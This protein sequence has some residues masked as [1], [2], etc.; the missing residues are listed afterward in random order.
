MSYCIATWR[1]ITVDF[2]TSTSQNGDWLTSTNVPY[3]DLFHNCSLISDESNQKSYILVIF[4]NNIGFLMKVEAHK[5]KNRLVT[6]TCQ[7]T[8]LC[9]CTV[10]GK[11]WTFNFPTELIASVLFGFSTF[12][13]YF[14]S[15]L[16]TCLGVSISITYTDLYRRFRRQFILSIL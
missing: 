15:F 8:P 14:F 12:F 1:C 10:S 2:T 11:N 16:F 6:Y 4:L 13:W 9:S 3:S 5:N 7:D